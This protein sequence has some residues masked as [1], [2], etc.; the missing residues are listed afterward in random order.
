MLHYAFKTFQR[1]TIPT[2]PL[3]AVSVGQ[4]KAKMGRLIV[5]HILPHNTH[6]IDRVVHK[7]RYAIRSGNRCG[8]EHQI[9]GGLP[10]PQNHLFSPVTQ[11]IG[12]YRRRSL[13]TITRR[14]RL[15]VSEIDTGLAVVLLD[16]PF[17]DGAYRQGVRRKDH[18]PSKFGN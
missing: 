2:A 4:I 16:I 5:G 15:Q 14:Y 11:Y 18:R 1:H 12:T 8:K 13:G 9:R 10:I 6:A 3:T 7:G 17:R